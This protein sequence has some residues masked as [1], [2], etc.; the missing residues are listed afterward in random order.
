MQGIAIS[1]C[2]KLLNKAGNPTGKEHIDMIK[3]F[4]QIAGKER[5]EGV[6]GDREFASGQFFKWLNKQA[7]P[8]YIRIKEGSQVC[9]RNR[10]LW[11]AKKVFCGLNPK[12]FKSYDMS[13]YPFGAKVYLAW[14]ATIKPIPFY[15][16][17]DIQRP[18]YSYFRYRSDLIRDLIIHT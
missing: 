15:K 9:I 1:I 10:K 17:R 3:S 18:K 8:F 6:L 12:E 5:I 2:W 4:V 16:Y 13:V 14:R 11:T 7:I